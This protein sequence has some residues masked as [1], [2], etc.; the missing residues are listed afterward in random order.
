MAIDWEKKFLGIRLAHESMMF[1]EAQKLLTQQR[2]LVKAHSAA[3]FPGS[4]DATEDDTMI[5]VG[6]ATTHNHYQSSHTNGWL[7]K[8][9]IGAALGAG[10]LATGGAGAFGLA[11]LLKPGVTPLAP[12][13]PMDM[14]IPWQLKDGKLQLGQP[15][16]S[17]PDITIPNK[18]N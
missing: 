11:S 13:V 8:M 1:D 2:A 4:T 10:L 12:A 14:E 15:R 9:L 16:Q 3:H 5:H 18:T 7:S 17:I 6:D